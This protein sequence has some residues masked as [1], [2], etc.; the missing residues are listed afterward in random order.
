MLRVMRILPLLLG[1]A[2]CGNSSY[3]P[4][5]EDDLVDTG[6]LVLGPEPTIPC[7]TTVTG[8]PYSLTVINR[9]RQDVHLAIVDA[10]CAEAMQATVP[11][12]ESVTL[13]GNP[14]TIWVVRTTTGAYVKHFDVPPGVAEWPVEVP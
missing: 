10:S 13:G 9:L 5:F 2:A 7:S 8:P 1:L 11:G 14:G 4:R 6:E 12:H 3:Y